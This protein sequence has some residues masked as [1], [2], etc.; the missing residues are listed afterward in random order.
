MKFGEE[1]ETLEYKTSLSEEHEAIKSLAA[2]ASARG[3]KLVFGVKPDGTKVG[4]Q[5]GKGKLEEF[6]SHI[7]QNTRPSLTPSI[8]E[9]EEDGK[10]FLIVKIDSHP[11]K[12]VWAYNV[13]Y[14]RVGRTNQKLDPEEIQ[15]L[16]DKS[17]GMT[18]DM[19]PIEDWRDSDLDDD[20]FASYLTMCGQKASSNP[21]HQLETL[22][23][24]RNG[25]PTYAMALLFAKNPQRYVPSAWVQC[26]AF[27]GESTTKFLDKSNFEGNII[28][29][30]EKSIAFIKRNSR[31]GV[32]I[33][34]TP[35]HQSQSEY[36]EVAVREAII[37]AIS[38]RDYTSAATTQIRIYGHRLEIWNPGQLPPELTLE[39]LYNEHSSY[40][41]N[42]LLK[43]T[44]A[45]VDIGER[46]GTGTTRIIDE[47]HLA[48]TVRPEFYQE[49]GLFKVRLAGLHQRIYESIAGLGERP[50]QAVAHVL[51][52]GSINTQTYVQLAKVS[53]RTARGELMQ[54][55]EREIFERIGSG[56]NT[57]YALTP[58]VV[59]AMERQL[60]IEQSGIAGLPE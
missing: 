31:Q 45:R 8:E 38:H 1:W 60:G 48:G 56:K 55:V 35:R 46:W 2:F 22:N 42:R 26:G 36:P 19:L 53:E 12:P 7:R 24:L 13:A 39:D 41:R 15:R 47:C 44:L 10:V 49:Q 21:L 57:C 43:E 3:G 18:W 20:R 23:L 32:H 51:Q 30:I 9:I 54:L 52:H 59:A 37:N 11:S 17:R 6:A 28:E 25:R 34:G 33:T 4:V 29:Q 50:R 14:K 5:I 40:P 58:S 16:L 27:E